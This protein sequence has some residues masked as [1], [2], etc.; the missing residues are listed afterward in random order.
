[1]VRKQDLAVEK[2]DLEYQKFSFF[3][4]LFVLT[5][6]SISCVFANRKGK[7]RKTKIPP[8][9]GVAAAQLTKTKKQAG[10]P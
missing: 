6:Y 9:S 10:R 7:K 8:K 5:T 1:V 2:Q 3:P 4:F